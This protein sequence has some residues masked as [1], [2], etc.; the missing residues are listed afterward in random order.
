MDTVHLRIS[1]VEQAKICLEIAEAR[2]QLSGL[3]YD[4]P[5]EGDSAVMG[6]FLRVHE[7]LLSSSCKTLETLNINTFMSPLTFLVLPPMTNVKILIIEEPSAEAGQVLSL[8]R[9]VDYPKM[10]PVLNYVRLNLLTEEDMEPNENHW[11]TKAAAAEAQLQFRPSTS[12]KVLEVNV[13]LVRVTFQDLRKIFPHVTAIAAATR[14]VDMVP[15]KQLWSCWPQLESVSLEGGAALKKNFD[16]TFLG[17]NP[18]ECDLLRELDE[19]LLENMN[20]VP[21]RPCILTMPRKFICIRVEFA[22]C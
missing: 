11:V 6:S 7:N 13:D 16:A 15:Y 20:I 19:K 8:L 22:T 10:L 18:E 3:S 4:V 12:V 21:I 9:S 17:I 5:S 14:K 2:P 1:S